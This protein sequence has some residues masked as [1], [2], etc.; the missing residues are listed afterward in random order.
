MTDKPW[1]TE[2]DH[3]L[4]EA[5]GYV[6]E[7]KRNGMGALCGYIYVPLDHPVVAVVRNGGDDGLRVHG[8][9]TFYDERDGMYVFGF[10]CAHAGDM[11]PMM[12]RYHH[13]VYRT[14]EYVTNE[15]ENLA[16]QLKERNHAN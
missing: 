13:E 8:G 10:D 14:I 16:Q 5:H 2:P 1:E 6:C 9:I 12:K 15:L 11:S 4:T 3:L 7:I